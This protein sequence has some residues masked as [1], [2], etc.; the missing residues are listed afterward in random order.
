MIVTL[1]RDDFLRLERARGLCIEV[2]S[3]RIWMTETGRGGDAVLEPGRACRVAGD[4]MVLIAPEARGGERT[5]TRARLRFPAHGGPLGRLGRW[6]RGMLG[7]I[8]GEI[9][10]R[11]TLRELE[12]LSDHT[13]RDIG[14]RREQIGELTRAG[15]RSS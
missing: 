6:L 7:A 5:E 4:G 8:A 15:L 13:L 12:S 11:R 14:L 9:E 1:Q 3:G 10:L 2:L